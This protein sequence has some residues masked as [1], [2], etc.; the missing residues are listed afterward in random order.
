[1]SSTETAAETEAEAEAASFGEE[2]VATVETDL[3]AELEAVPGY[4]ASLLDATRE[5]LLDGADG[6]TLLD[7]WYADETLG[8]PALG[9]LLQRPGGT[10]TIAE[11]V[12]GTDDRVRITATTA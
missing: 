8:D 6:R 7:A 4:D 3:E 5:T 2:G 9:A 10:E 1:M 12:I 11:V